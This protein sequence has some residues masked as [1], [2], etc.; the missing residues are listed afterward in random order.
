MGEG[1]RGDSH[2]QSPRWQSAPSTITK[3]VKRREIQHTYHFWLVS[4]ATYR[5]HIRKESRRVWTRLY[6][7]RRFDDYSALFSRMVS[8]G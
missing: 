8:Q 6:S 7:V 4:L 1:G 2:E 5:D 3:H